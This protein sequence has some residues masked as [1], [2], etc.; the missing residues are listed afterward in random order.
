[1]DRGSDLARAA[2]PCGCGDD[3]ERAMTAHGQ[4]RPRSDAGKIVGPASR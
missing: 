4:E 3:G 1:M 2:G